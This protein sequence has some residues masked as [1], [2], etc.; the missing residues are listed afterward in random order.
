MHSSFFLRARA[1]CSMGIV[2]AVPAAMAGPASAVIDNPGGGQNRIEV[3]GNTAQNIQ[4]DCADGTRAAGSNH[5]GAANVNS[6]NVDKNSLQGR[7]TIITG[8]NSRD[9]RAEADCK[10]GRPAVGNVNSVNIR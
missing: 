2:A 3:T 1:W 8:R 5:R 9:V 7:T 6:V 10:S 4:V